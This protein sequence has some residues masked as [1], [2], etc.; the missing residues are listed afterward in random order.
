MMMNIIIIIT[1]E[2]AAVEAGMEQLSRQLSAHCTEHSLLV[3]YL[4]RQYSG[5]ARTSH[6]LLRVLQALHHSGFHDHRFS[7]Q[8]SIHDH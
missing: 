2:Q 3:E 1:S 5:V 6:E 8:L 7:L 4:H